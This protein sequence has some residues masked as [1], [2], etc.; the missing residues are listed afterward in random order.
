MVEQLLEK[1]VVSVVLP[2]DLD[3][4]KLQHRRVHA[5]TRVV[6]RDLIPLT[7]V[8]AAVRLLRSVAWRF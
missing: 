3:R 5:L 1:R 6:S 8:R 7:L 4:A 2:D